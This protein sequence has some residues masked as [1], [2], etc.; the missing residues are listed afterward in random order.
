[1]QLEEVV[2]LQE[3]VVE[4]E[5]RQTGLESGAIG[6]H[7]EHLVDREVAPVIAQELDVVQRS[8][9]RRVV[10]HRR[11][12]RREIEIVFQLAPNGGGVGVDLFWS[13][14]PPGGRP[15]GRVA[16]HRRPA[17]DE[18][19]GT[20]PGA[21]EVRHRHDADQVPE[22]QRVGRGIAAV[23]EGHLTGGEG[24]TEGRLIGALIDESPLLQNVVD[25]PRRC[26]RPGRRC[27]RGG[28][29]LG[30]SCG[31]RWPAMAGG[32]WSDRETGGGKER[33]AQ[34]AA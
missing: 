22:V 1:V 8:Q 24:A 7:A 10:D 9:P 16:D 12:A 28:H 21:L 14:D 18:R 29:R 3:H 26:G 31:D 33:R 25:V 15:V 30:S 2:G 11:L 4:L 13:H 34:P 32:S 17:A 19:D 27:S 5:E 23:V 20:V 6:L